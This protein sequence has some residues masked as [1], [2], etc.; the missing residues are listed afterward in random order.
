M[1]KKTDEKSLNSNPP[2]AENSEDEE[3]QE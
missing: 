2:S 3:P 1:E